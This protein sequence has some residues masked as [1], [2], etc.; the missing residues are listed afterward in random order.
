[1]VNVSIVL[2]KHSIL[3]VKPL[4]EML[5]KSE[6]VSTVFLIDNSPELTPGYETLGVNYYFTGKNIG[7]GAGHN[8][9]IR[10]T[11]AQDIPYHLVL[12]PDISFDPR[13]LGQIKC[14]MNN[15][16]GI[17]HIMPKVYYPNREIQYLCKLI[18]TPFDLIFR[19]FLPDKLTLKRTSKFELRDSGYNK[20]IDVPYLSGCFM[21]LRTQALKDVGIFD[22]R[23]F[24]YPE[25]IDLTRRIHQKYR[26]VYYPDVKIIHHHAQSS[27]IDYKMLMIHMV[28]MI[29]YFNKWGWVF[30]KERRV[31]NREILK[32]IPV[33][34][35]SKHKLI[36][37]S[38]CEYFIQKGERKRQ[39]IL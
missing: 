36:H 30:D 37:Q 8:L 33:K 11:I 7:Y 5:N 27:Y 14:F 16:T 2:Y 4:I 32:Q 1:M 23:F 3:E 31:V 24:M 19:R 21:F 29:K 15:N 13:I 35:K 28:N 17:G 34:Q 25:D 20:L 26:T 39:H 38:S 18:P 22:E 6:V 9:A 12:N 10:Q